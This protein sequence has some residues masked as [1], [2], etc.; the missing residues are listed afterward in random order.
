M[1]ISNA[2]KLLFNSIKKFSTY[3]KQYFNK[4][5]IYDC[6][7]CDEY[8]EFNSSNPCIPS[9]T[10]TLRFKSDE[11]GVLEKKIWPNLTSVMELQDGGFCHFTNTNVEFKNCS[12]V[13]FKCK[14]QIGHISINT[15]VQANAVTNCVKNCNIIT[16]A[17]KI[18]ISLIPET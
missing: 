14:M 7:D 13:N 3:I 18:Y 15:I 4:A 5:P 8:S 9:E 6:D 12:N 10:V 16:D 1:N 2:I 17:G 11:T